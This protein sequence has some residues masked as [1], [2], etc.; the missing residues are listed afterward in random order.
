[1]LILSRCNL[2][3]RSQV[4][5]TVKMLEE[6]NADCNDIDTILDIIKQDRTRDEDK[7]V[8]EVCIIIFLINVIITFY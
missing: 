6:K 3:C 7:E 8:I 5:K 2:Y 1:M 4:K